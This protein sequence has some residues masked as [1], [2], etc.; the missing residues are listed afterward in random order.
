MLC[1]GTASCCP[2]EVP[3]PG[4]ST[5]SRLSTPSDH[6]MYEVRDFWL[7][8]AFPAPEKKPKPIFY[9]S[10]SFKQENPKCLIIHVF[11]AQGNI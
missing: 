1:L 2:E 11:I 3:S 9:S 5:G 7:S 10:S 8:S 4:W 6:N